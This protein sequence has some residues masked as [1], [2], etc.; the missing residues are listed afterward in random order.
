MDL[1]EAR[2]VAYGTLLQC[3]AG[4]AGL[5]RHPGRAPRVGMAW[6]DPMCGL[7]LAFAVA[8]AVWRRRRGAASRIDFSM[9]EAMLWTMAEPLFAA[10]E[11]AAPKAATGSVWPCVGEDAWVATGPLGVAPSADQ[12][13]PDAAQAQLRAGIPAASLASSLDLVN[14]LHLHARGFWEKTEAG[15]LPG[16]PWQASFGSAHGPARPLGADTD[17]V[18]HETLGMTQAEIATLR[19]DGVVG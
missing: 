1:T 8:A 7:M 14:D 13:A 6:L 12:S 17:S 3:Y 4:F 10:Q 19:R 9:I 18:L 15:T 5:N 16:L 2:A 11:Q